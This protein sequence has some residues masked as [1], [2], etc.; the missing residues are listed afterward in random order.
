MGE[1]FHSVL[2]GSSLTLHVGCWLGLK[3]YKGLAGAGRAASEVGRSH[4]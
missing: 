1:E 4:G 2:A 3:V